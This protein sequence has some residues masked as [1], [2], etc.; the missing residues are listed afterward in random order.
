MNISREKC[1]WL[2]IAMLILLGA[3]LFLNAGK[4]TTLPATYYWMI[5]GSPAGKLVLQIPSG[6]V[7]EISLPSSD[8]IDADGR[9]QLVF[10]SFGPDELDAIRKNSNGMGLKLD[11]VPIAARPKEANGYLYLDL[12]QH[13][14]FL[15]PDGKLKAVATILLQERAAR[16]DLVHCA[17]GGDC[18]G[19]LVQFAGPA[20]GSLEGPFPGAYVSATNDPLPRGRWVKDLTAGLQIQATHPTRLALRMSMLS[21][22]AEQGVGLQ[23]AVLAVNVAMSGDKSRDYLGMRLI[24]MTVTAMVDLHAGGND[25]VL[26]FSSALHPASDPGNIQAAFMTD[27]ELYTVDY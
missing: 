15:V 24:P 8:I 18:T 12:P 6:G 17:A 13:K 9:R 1:V 26:V 22:A 16:K 5:N 3:Y 14:L 19:V 20:W 21:V 2:P 4:L 7:K 27:I 11:G 10:S 25:F 23:G